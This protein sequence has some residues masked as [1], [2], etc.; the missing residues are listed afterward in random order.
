MDAISQG[1]QFQMEQVEHF[2]DPRIGRFWTKYSET[3]KR[4]R[5]PAKAIPWYRR[6]IEEFMSDHP[7]LRLR[8][9]TAESV[10]Q[11]LGQIGRNPHIDDWQFRQKVDALRI[12]MGHLL[13]L[14]WSSDFD[15]ERWAAGARALERN[16]PTIARTYEDDR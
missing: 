6:H 16:H 11:W 2:S 14:P 7:D 4:F 3:L 1:A 8:S 12:L 5:V 10:A 15:W 13:R 9:H